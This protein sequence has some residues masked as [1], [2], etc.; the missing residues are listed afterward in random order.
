M[1]SPY[2]VA[3]LHAKNFVR[4][5]DGVLRLID[6]VAAPWPDAQ[7]HRS[8]LITE[9]LGRV[10]DDPAASALPEAPDDEL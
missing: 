7:A 3:D 1:G 4:G 6:L 2:L 10:R 5:A 9:W 8:P